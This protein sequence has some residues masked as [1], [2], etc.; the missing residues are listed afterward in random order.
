[1]RKYINS[2][3][4][5]NSQNFN[6]I[7]LSPFSWLFT[8]FKPNNKKQTKSI[9]NLPVIFTSD[10]QIETRTKIHHHNR[11]RLKEQSM[12]RIRDSC[13]DP[14]SIWTLSVIKYGEI[15]W[16]CVNVCE[17]T[18]PGKMNVRK[19]NVS[20]IRKIKSRVNIKN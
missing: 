10:L 20:I 14:S 12:I 1:M 16:T 4:K 13:I 15:R 3:S 8:N 19:D 7:N 17:W 6:L 18:V 9:N 11:R 5:F 2:I